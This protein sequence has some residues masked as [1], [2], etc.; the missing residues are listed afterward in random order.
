MP[1]KGWEYCVEWGVS[2]LKGLHIVKLGWSESLFETTS[3]IL[4]ILIWNFHEYRL[5]AS[6]FSDSLMTSK[7]G[8]NSPEKI[9]ETAIGMNIKFLSDV[10]IYQEAE[11][12]KTCLV[13]NLQTKILKTPIFGNAPS[14]HA[15]VTRFCRIITIDV[16]KWSWKFQIDISK[17]D[18]FAIKNCSVKHRTAHKVRTRSRDFTNR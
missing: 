10:G 8:G 5:M 6:A 12:K 16:R 14:R 7:G 4:E 9:S 18:Y 13:C 17:T 2:S 15:N 1:R 11:N 3:P